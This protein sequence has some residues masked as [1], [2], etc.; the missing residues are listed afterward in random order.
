MKILPLVSVIFLLGVTSSCSQN[1]DRSPAGYRDKQE[2]V[3]TPGDYTQGTDAHNQA[4]R[5][6]PADSKR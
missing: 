6:G 1:D 4:R 3:S 5:Y 2:Q